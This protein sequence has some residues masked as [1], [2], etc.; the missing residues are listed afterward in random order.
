M[1]KYIH[2]AGFTL[3][4]IALWTLSDKPFSQIITPIKNAIASQP[5]ISPAPPIDEDIT[6]IRIVSGQ[7]IGYVLDSMKGRPS[8]V[9]VYASWCPHCRVA[10]PDIVNLASKFENQVLM[11]STD[12]SHEILEQYIKENPDFKRENLP[13]YMWSGEGILQQSLSR[14]GIKLPRGIPFIALL[15][16]HGYI[17]DQGH[18]WP[19]RIEE[20]LQ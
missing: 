1:R 17:V 9:F 18:F 3:V 5:V 4:A 15:D 14:F 8:A 16:E 20:H 6:P 10:M 19:K 11:L 13:F 2:F 12:R 7:Q